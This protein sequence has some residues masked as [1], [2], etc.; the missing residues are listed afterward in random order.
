M[1]VVRPRHERTPEIITL[2][3]TE[4]EE[5][6]TEA[7]QESASESR[8]LRGKALKRRMKSPVRNQ[9]REKKEKRL[10]E[11]KRKKCE[12]NYTRLPIFHFV[13]SFFY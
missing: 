4:E 7:S 8:S 9:Q 5:E 11:N 1:R 3:D 2:S 10:K 6:E 12:S 13:I